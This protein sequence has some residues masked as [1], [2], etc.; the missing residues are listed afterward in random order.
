MRTLIFRWRG[1]MFI[2]TALLVLHLAQP[3]VAS[4]VFGLMV[5]LAGELLRCWGVGYSGVT[6]RDSKVV[7]PRLVTAGPYAFVRNPLY[8]G[9]FITAL[10]FGF[11][12]S[13]GLCWSTR[14]AL[15]ALLA[16]H[17][18][19]VYAGAIIPLEEE[20]LEG[21][22]GE[23][24]RSYLAAVPRLLPSLR[25]YPAAEGTFD[26]RVIASAEIHTLALFSVM[27][28]VMGLR[29]EHPA[30]AVTEMVRLLSW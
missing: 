13:G 12:A 14:L 25:A 7:A 30:A 9:N 15:Y 17:Y 24:Y 1:Y 19:A 22:F 26:P 4:F 28:I 5:A 21:T 20:Y 8:L 2:P 10:G 6:T 27:V 29:L 3:T 23:P 16:A 18:A 11:V